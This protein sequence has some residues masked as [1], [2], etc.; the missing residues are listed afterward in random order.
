MEYG[1]SLLGDWIQATAVTHTTVVA[2]PDPLTQ[3]AGLGI[4]PA[5]PQ[6]PEQLELDS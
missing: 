4:E 1:S 5:P 6:G 3:Q 2:T